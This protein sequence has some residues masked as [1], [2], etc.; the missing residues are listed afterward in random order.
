M[1]RPPS[2]LDLGPHELRPMTP[3]E[4]EIFVMA[5]LSPDL[6]EKRVDVDSAIFDGVAT[7]ITMA[8]GAIVARLAVANVAVTPAALVVLASWSKSPGDLVLW[9]YACLCL[10]QRRGLDLVTLQDLGFHAFPM[11]VP[12]D[13]A[14][15]RIWNAQKHFDS[16]EANWLD[17]EKAWAS[18]AMA[19]AAKGAAA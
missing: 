12:T 10:A 13:D 7:S 11:G 18:E 4:S 2:L 5:S 17:L 9:A 14:K 3:T 6:D 1:T 8:R 15:T 16:A 19:E